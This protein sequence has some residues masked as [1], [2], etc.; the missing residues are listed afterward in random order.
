MPELLAERRALIAH[1]DHEIHFDEFLD[2][3]RRVQANGRRVA[4]GGI[5]EAVLHRLFDPFVTT[6]RPARGTGLG[7]FICHGLAV[8]RGGGAAAGGWRAALRPPL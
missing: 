8:G 5:A 4:G 6:N 3:R 1:D 2:A 7:L